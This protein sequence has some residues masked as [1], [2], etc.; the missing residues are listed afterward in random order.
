VTEPEPLPE[1]PDPRPDPIDLMHE[2]VDMLTVRKL[3]YG[4]G[5]NEYAVLD[6][7]PEVTQSAAA[8]FVALLPQC[9]EIDIEDG[10]VKG[11][12]VDV[13]QLVGRLTAAGFAMGRLPQNRSDLFSMPDGSLLRTHPPDRC[14]GEFCCMHKP[15]EHPLNTAPL[16]WRQDRLLM[17][18][19]CT[20]GIGHPD[21]DHLAFTRSIS[22][23]DADGQ[24]VH[25]C[26][27]CCMGVA[28]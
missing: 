17:E 19:M 4:L 1:L 20:H 26:D 28:L 16:N 14:E 6:L 24:S 2:H 18:R 9:I 21:P 5:S 23:E 8:L 27:G 10:D 7:A 12:M 11:M 15:S 13:P 25:G 3:M 22:T